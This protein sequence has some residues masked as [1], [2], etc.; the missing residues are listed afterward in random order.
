ML[1]YENNP[2]AYEKKCWYPRNACE[3]YCSAIWVALIPLVGLIVGAVILS[4]G[5]SD[6][7]SS[8]D[9]DASLDFTQLPFTCTITE[10]VSINYI[11]LLI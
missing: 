11:E 3:F 5:I 8:K 4:V 6:K 2:P 10:A 9:L 1:Q 7:A